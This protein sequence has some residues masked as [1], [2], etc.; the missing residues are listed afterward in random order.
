MNIKNIILLIL[1]F[2]YTHYPFA[3]A[4]NPFLPWDADV[5]I[6]DEN[7]QICGSHKKKI[8]NVYNGTQGGA[9]LLIRFFQIVISPQDGPNCRYKPTCSAYGAVAVQRF[10]AIIGAMLAGDRIIR[11]NPFSPFGDDPVPESILGK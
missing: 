11:C 7:L 6:G 5:K 1:L 10:G 2:Q 3:L 8:I 4:E 9:Y